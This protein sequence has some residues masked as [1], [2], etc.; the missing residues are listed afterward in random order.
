MVVKYVDYSV[1]SMRI[2]GSHGRVVR[3]ERLCYHSFIHSSIFSFFS[4]LFSTY[5]F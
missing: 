1:I 4:I 2:V 5:S 3:G